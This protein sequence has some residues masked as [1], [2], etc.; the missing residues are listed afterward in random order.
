[1]I[2]KQ[3]NVVVAVLAISAALSGCK[4]FS[5]V[6]VPAHDTEAPVPAVGLWSAATQDYVLIRTGATPLVFE[7]SDPEAAFLAVASGVDSGGIKQVKLHA[8]SRTF[9]SRGDISSVQTGTY[10]DQMNTQNGAVGSTVQNGLWS[11]QTIRGRDLDTCPA[12][13]TLTEAIFSWSTEVKDFH[14]NTSALGGTFRY[15]P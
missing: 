11:G 12:G 9:C 15:K 13:F 14:D 3:R 2:F 8:S 7:T 5:S 1:M 10:T 6:V 4:Y